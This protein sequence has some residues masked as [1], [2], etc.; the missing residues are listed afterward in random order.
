M[1]RVNWLAPT[2]HAL[3]GGGRSLRYNNAC[4]FSQQLNTSFHS[5]IGSNMLSSSILPNTWWRRSGGEPLATFC[6]SPLSFLSPLLGIHVR[7][8]R[9]KGSLSF[10]FC[11]KFG[12]YFFLW[13]FVLFW[14]FFLNWFFFNNFPKHWFHLVFISN[15]TLVL[16]IDIYFV[17]DLFLKLHSSVFGLNFYVTFG[18][19]SFDCYMFCF[20]IHFWL[21]FFISISSL[22]I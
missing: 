18:P 2:T 21:N 12:S 22:N 5:G 8:P 11:I 20:F 9:L 6:S 13:L 16:L 15:L 17:L 14:I 19:Y 4:N 10:Y 3:T 7:L 1:G